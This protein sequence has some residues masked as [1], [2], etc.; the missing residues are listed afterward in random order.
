MCR[1]GMI[2]SEHEN[3]CKL[4]Y[5]AEWLAPNNEGTVTAGSSKQYKTSDEVPTVP[6]SKQ[7]AQ[8]GTGPKT[9]LN[10]YTYGSIID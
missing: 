5:F 6:S 1:L 4:L 7:V 9:P 10:G 2:D 8:R 3:L